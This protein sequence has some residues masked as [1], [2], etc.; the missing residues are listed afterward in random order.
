MS[1][2]RRPNIARAAEREAANLRVN[3]SAPALVRPHFPGVDTSAWTDL[4]PAQYPPDAV[5]FI[6]TAL[7]LGEDR[8]TVQLYRCDACRMIVVTRD[9]HPGYS[10]RFVDHRHFEPATSC[11][12]VT[13]TL[14]HIDEAPPA[15]PSHEWYRP[16]ERELLDLPDAFIDHVLRGG[17]LLRL[18]PEGDR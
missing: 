10:P 8:R 1:N 14:G 17:L 4:P 7:E 18:I 13:R 6:R 11:T 12:G 15:P 2:R 3:G 9:R 16:G 5:A